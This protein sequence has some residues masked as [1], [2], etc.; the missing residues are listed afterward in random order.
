MADDWQQQLPRYSYRYAEEEPLSAEEA[1][2]VLRDCPWHRE[3]A[4]P[5]QHPAWREFVAE[6]AARAALSDESRAALAAEE[7]VRPVLNPEDESDEEDN[8]AVPPVEPVQPP[9]QPLRR[10]AEPAWT[11]W[12]QGPEQVG[13]LRYGSYCAAPSTVKQWRLRKVATRWRYMIQV[14]LWSGDTVTQ[15][16]HPGVLQAVRTRQRE[17]SDDLWTVELDHEEAH[18]WSPREIK[19]QFDKE[20]NALAFHNA[21]LTHLS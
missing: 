12:E 21:L 6:Q 9:V 14:R 11:E 16:V 8:A 7:G 20:E 18:G 2:A 1:R 15:M 3:P 19:F 13:S 17:G 10:V 5:H 4:R